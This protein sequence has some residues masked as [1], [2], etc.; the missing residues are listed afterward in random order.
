M[1]GCDVTYY[2]RTES[3]NKESPEAMPAR[4]HVATYRNG[5][6]TFRLD[7]P[8]TAHMDKCLAEAVS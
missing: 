1:A 5:L 3:E 2:I 8:M 6:A 4:S 7:T